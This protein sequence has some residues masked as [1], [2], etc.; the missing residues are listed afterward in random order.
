[1]IRRAKPDSLPHSKASSHAEDRG[2]SRQRA[3]TRE[4]TIGRSQSKKI[5]PIDQ[6][7]DGIKI[8]SFKMKEREMKRGKSQKRGLV[9][10]QP[11]EEL[12]AYLGSS[13]DLDDEEHEEPVQEQKGHK[14]VQFYSKDSEQK[15]EFLESSINLDTP[16][17]REPSFPPEHAMPIKTSPPKQNREPSMAE[18]MAEERRRIE[19]DVYKRIKQE[20]E[21]KAKEE[22]RRR[23]E[24]EQRE[25]AL[26]R[27]LEEKEEALKR[28][29]ERIDR[30]KELLRQ[31]KKLQED[32]ESLEKERARA[33]LEF[34]SEKK[35]ER[36][37][38]LMM[39]RERR[40]V[41]Q[42][43]SSTDEI[44]TDKKQDQYE[45]DQMLR[46]EVEEKE[47][48]RREISLRENELSKSIIEKRAPQMEYSG[49]KSTHTQ[50]YAQDEQITPPKEAFRR[51]LDQD[52]EF[53]QH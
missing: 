16:P 9:Q 33:T 10:V 32:R 1:M 3:K 38:Q 13:M 22:E 50:G 36:D 41:Y 11:T 27:Q 43:R 34:D 28:E 6:K 7:R 51:Q 5:I 31:E 18:L 20:M 52:L 26:L 37:R 42:R 53:Q 8:N 14:V 40:E 23:I 45:I 19:E 21:E 35:K 44:P 48:L 47:R 4:R 29:Q 12:H 39:E 15:E 2:R 24:I 49:T 46:R 30:E 17:Y 25:S